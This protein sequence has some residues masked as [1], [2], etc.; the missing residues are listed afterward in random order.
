MA[1][2]ATIGSSARIRQLNDRLRRTGMGGRIVLTAGVAALSPAAIAAI[3]A[4][5]ARFDAF[6]PHNDPHG[7]HD[8]AMI[9]VGR[10]SI[11]WKIDCYDPTLSFASHN[12]V[13][14]AVTSRVLTIMLAEEY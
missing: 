2:T 13:D 12:P 11:L 14:P 7:E 4:A 5:V 6:T 1:S 10:D 8:C 3:V 9:E